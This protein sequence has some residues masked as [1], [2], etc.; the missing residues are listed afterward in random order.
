MK[1]ETLSTWNMKHF[2]KTYETQNM[3]HFYKTYETQ[4]MNKHFQLKN[5]LKKMMISDYNM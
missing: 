3:K 1:H 4:N 2:Y 5:E